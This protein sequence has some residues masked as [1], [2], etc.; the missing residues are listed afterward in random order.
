MTSN[1]NILCS[2]SWVLSHHC[3][4]LGKGASFRSVITCKIHGDTDQIP[5]ELL[6]CMLDKSKLCSVS[7]DRSVLVADH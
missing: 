4:P 3:A 1:W 6:F 7:S 5:F 2:F